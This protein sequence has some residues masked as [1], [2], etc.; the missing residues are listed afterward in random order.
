[1]CGLSPKRGLEA[2]HDGVGILL[3]G[4][5]SVERPS[6]APESQCLTRSR[7]GIDRFPHSHMKRLPVIVVSAV[8]ILLAGVLLVGRR[9]GSPSAAAAVHDGK[10]LDVWLYRYF[11]PPTE[12]EFETSYRALKALRASSVPALAELCLENTHPPRWERLLIEVRRYL[13]DPHANLT[14]QDIQQLSELALRTFEPKGSELPPRR[15]GFSR[16]EGW[17]RFVGTAFPC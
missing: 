2:L 1:M 6:D 15:R 4:F 10:P 14:R 5:R 16:A 11:R 17:L 12:A 3:E 13:G 9:G 8:L 7:G